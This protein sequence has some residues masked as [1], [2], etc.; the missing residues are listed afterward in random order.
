MAFL[1]PLKEKYTIKKM[2]EKN[3]KYVGRTGN[4]HNNTKRLNQRPHARRYP[5][6]WIREDLIVRG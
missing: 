5:R 1:I 6:D 3:G 2:G 4:S